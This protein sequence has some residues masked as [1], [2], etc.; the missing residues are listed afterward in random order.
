M[1]RNQ[2]PSHFR[3]RGSVPR[4]KRT[5]QPI[6]EET[7]GC[8]YVE[9]HRGEIANSRG[10]HKGWRS[11]DFIINIYHRLQHNFD[12]L[13]GFY[14]RDDNL[15]NADNPL[16]EIDQSHPLDQLRHHIARMVGEYCGVF[17]G[18]PMEGQIRAAVGSA[19]RKMK[20]MEQEQKTK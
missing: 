6:G 20:T 3:N 16:E 13:G 4:V 14:G 11:N 5:P 18:F 9:C 12:L 2:G 17:I 19:Y 10:T 15:V 8:L 1:D 7:V